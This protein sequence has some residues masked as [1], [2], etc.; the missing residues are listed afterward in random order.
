MSAPVLRGIALLLALSGLVPPPGLAAEAQGS[1][2]SS[3]VSA[4]PRAADDVEG[5]RE[6]A[7][8]FWAARVAGDTNGQWQ[9]LE[10]RGRGRL[11]AGEYAS[12]RGAVKYI[13]YQVEDATVNGYF[14]SVKVRLL[15]LPILPTAQRNKVKPSGSLVA[16][17]WVRVGGTWY[18]S[19]EQGSTAADASQP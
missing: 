4:S 6:R 12:A 16:D 8:A 14:A 15:V 13:A 18:R 7:A 11:T 10:P 5:L 1:S 19:F 2:V 3:T 9:L 17:R